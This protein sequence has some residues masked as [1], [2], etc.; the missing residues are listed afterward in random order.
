MDSQ[1]THNA[2]VIEN[3]NKDIFRFK[4]LK[5]LLLPFA[6]K[7][8]GCVVPKIGLNNCIIPM[9]IVAAIVYLAKSVPESIAAAI[10]LSMCIAAAPIIVDPVIED[11]CVL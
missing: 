9:P 5:S 3:N 7:Y 8:R 6:S 10:I 11:N 1:R 4:A 2:N